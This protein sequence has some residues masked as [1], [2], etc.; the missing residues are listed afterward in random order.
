M[1]LQPHA[2]CVYNE[3]SCSLMFFVEE[4]WAPTAGLAFG[5]ISSIGVP[6]GQVPAAA[7]SQRGV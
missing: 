7:I 6:S 4:E 3:N 5:A 2:C 1:R